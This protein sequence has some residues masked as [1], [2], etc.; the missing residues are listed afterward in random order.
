MDRKL[1]PLFLGFVLVLLLPTAVPANEITLADIEIGGDTRVLR[2][3]DRDELHA[4]L[5]DEKSSAT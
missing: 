3:V 5:A 2:I 1:G 4:C